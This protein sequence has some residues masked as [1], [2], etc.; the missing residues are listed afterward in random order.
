[1]PSPNP[2]V[3][4]NFIHD[5]VRMDVP[6]AYFL[7]RVHD[8]DNMLVII[9]SRYKPFA[10]VVARRKQFSAGL[11]YKAIENTI[12]QPDTVMCFNYGV[13][14]VCL[15]FKTGPTWDV[16]A[17]LRSLAARDM[18]AHGGP[19]KVADML[20]AQEEAA[21]KKIQAEIRA[22]LYNRSGA[23]W[24]SYKARVGANNTSR[25]GGTLPSRQERRTN[26]TAPSGSTAG[27]GLVT[28]T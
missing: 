15:M 14:P 8:F 1:M 11:T 12:T 26:Q 20:E 22:D 2:W 28:L 25:Y 4:V 13:V 18:W 19:D 23:A 9:P 10:Y 3:G 7:Q 6:P 21:K 16:D 27:L 5:N 17:L 24:Q